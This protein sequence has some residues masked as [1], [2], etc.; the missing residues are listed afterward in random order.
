MF[1]A[2]ETL[3]EVRFEFI[4]ADG[5]RHVGVVVKTFGAEEV[6]AIDLETPLHEHN[7]V[8]EYTK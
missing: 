6:R 1:N 7:Q 5:L 3:V 2:Q 4:L 8:C